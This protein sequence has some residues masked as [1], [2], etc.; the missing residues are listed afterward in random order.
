MAEVA[1]KGEAMAG[2]D[3]RHVEKSKSLL[4]VYLILKYFEGWWLYLS[5][6]YHVRVQKKPEEWALNS[7]FILS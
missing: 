7:Y 6:Y 3:S 4:I 5:L 2:K 1:A